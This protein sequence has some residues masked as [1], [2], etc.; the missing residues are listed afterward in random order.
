MFA[1]FGIK[2][3]SPLESAGDGGVA[4]P[5][6]AALSQELDQLELGSLAGSSAAS[7]GSASA[8]EKR[9]ADEAA[10][11][12]A[13]R[14]V[15]PANA[16]APAAPSPIRP[17]AAGGGLGGIGSSAGPQKST[18]AGTGVSQAIPNVKGNASVGGAAVSG[19]TVSNAAR[20]VAGMRAGFRACFQRGLAED[21]TLQGG[22]LRLTINVAVDGTVRSATPGA[23]TGNLPA[24]V[25][26]CVVGRAIRAQFDAPEGGNATITVPVTFTVQPGDPTPAVTSRPIFDI[27]AAPPDVAVNRAGD[28]AWLSQGQAALDKLQAELAAVPT[29]RKRNEALVRGLLLR[30]RFAPAL[31]AAQKFVELDPDLPVARELLAYAAVATGDRNRAAAAVD[32]LTESAPNELKTQGRAARTFEALGDETR[33]CAHWRSVFELAPSSDSAQ[34]EAFRCRARSMADREAALRDAKAVTKP[35]PLLQKLLPLLESGQLPAFERSSGGVGQFEVTLTCEP[36]TDCPYAI[37]ITPTG[38]V[39]S[40][41]TPAL[42]RSSATSFAFSGLMTGVYH[43][44][45]VGG[46]PG[47]KGQLEVRALNT[48]NSFP[49]SAGHAPTLVTTQVTMSPGASN[50]LGL[51]RAF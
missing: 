49:F 43:V 4:G 20:V 8:P 37:V 10:A 17:G 3:S 29:S 27:G 24:S 9:A 50:N 13:P 22:S 28:E 6:R 30:G 39:F 18:A 36:K 47:A 16:P 5:D 21:P 12:S 33:A 32:A 19:G 11:P 46:A 14:S 40:P 51:L 25:V 7:N 41:W 26:G 42:G 48:R 2:R 23:V 1:E 31:A 44:L 35:G 38:T 15:P 34:F 45:L